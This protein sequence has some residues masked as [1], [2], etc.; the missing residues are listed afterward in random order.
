[1]R[2]IAI[3]II[4]LS[5][6][7]SVFAEENQDRIVERTESDFEER[8]AP[9]VGNS[10]DGSGEDYE[11]TR[12]EPKTHRP[13]ID[14]AELFSFVKND[15]VSISS[16]VKNNYGPIPAQQKLPA[17]LKDPFNVNSIQ[18]FD[19]SL[20]RNAT[21]RGLAYYSY[22]PY[23]SRIEDDCNEFLFTESMRNFFVIAGKYIREL[24]DPLRVVSDCCSGYT[25]FYHL[26]ENRRRFVFVASDLKLGGTIILAELDQDL[27]VIN[28]HNLSVLSSMLESPEERV[29]IGGALNV[30]DDMYFSLVNESFA[31][32]S[33]ANSSF[34]VKI[35]LASNQ[36][37]W[38]SPAKTCNS[39]FTL[40]DGNLITS[41]GGSY[42]SDYIYSIGASDGVPVG[43]TKIPTA[44]D[45]L[46]KAGNTILGQ[47]YYGVK[48]S[49]TH[50]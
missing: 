31:E 47:R 16:I 28:A 20:V 25:A 4:C 43:R 30:D 12:N 50:K 3:L 41:Y 1:M 8:A 46:V 15:P 34:V 32:N 18:A 48:F 21:M 11:Q 44:A 49:V 37:A 23:S 40:V 14:L 42:H 35:N 19:E 10:N 9:V 26:S 17:K 38:I 33:K 5:I 6:A 27:R 22:I 7:C 2:H 29:M 24:G 13:Q 45:F 36:I 39:E